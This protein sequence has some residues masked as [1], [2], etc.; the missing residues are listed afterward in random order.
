MTVLVILL[1]PN[2]RHGS[3][4]RQTRQP[5]R[6][7]LI[8]GF[9][10]DGSRVAAASSGGAARRLPGI[11]TMPSLFRFLV[12]VGVI[13]GLSYVSVFALANFFKPQPREIIVTVPSS[14]YVKN[15]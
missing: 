10:D 6:R 4:Y 7:C 2:Q 13:V 3:T 15:P 5:R 12:F 8:T 11:W 14:K 9:A 1:C